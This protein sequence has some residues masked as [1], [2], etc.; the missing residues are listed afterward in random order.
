M[1][2]RKFNE[3]K[4]EEDNSASG[5]DTKSL[6][7]TKDDLIGFVSDYEEVKDKEVKKIKKEIQNDGETPG[8]KK[9]IKKFEE[10]SNELGISDDF[11]DPTDTYTINRQDSIELR[12]DSFLNVGCEC[13]SDCTGQKDCECGCPNCECEIDEDDVDDISENIKYHLVNSLPIIENVFRPGSKE[14]FNLI[15]EARNLYDNGLIELKGVDKELYEST[16]IG[17][18][19][20]FKGEIVPLD[21]PMEYIEEMN[22]AEYKGKEVKL[23]HP[24]RNSG[25]GKKYYVYVKN[26]KTGNVKKISFGDVHGGLTAK[27]SNAEARKSFVARHRCKRKWKPKD[28]LSAGYWSCHLPRYKNLVKSSHGGY[29]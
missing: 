19:A 4:K 8:L 6:E 20:K 17:K 27:V 1:R 11:G 2:I 26:P 13:C 22:E 25:G 14:F 9:S 7:P 28:K 12:G 3:N 24:M 23:N 10:F 18:F 29:W 16:E 15:K 21:I 5:F